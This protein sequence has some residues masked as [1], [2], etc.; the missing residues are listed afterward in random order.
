MNSRPWIDI[1]V[2]V[3][4]IELIL[5]KLFSVLPMGLFSYILNEGRYE[6]TTSCRRVQTKKP[7]DI[8]V[9]INLC[10][11]INIILI[12]NISLLILYYYH[13]ISPDL[14]SRIPGRG[15]RPYVVSNAYMLPHV[16]PPP[17]EG[18]LSGIAALLWWSRLSC[19]RYIYI[20]IYNFTYIYIYM[21]M[22][23]LLRQS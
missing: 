13:Y 12:V 21:Y 9:V 8:Y 17:H 15:A 7:V 23:I 2:L 10:I 6:L 4:N 18:W 16:A 19:P 1:M 22:Y 5:Y 20:Y 3:A 14:G 11:I